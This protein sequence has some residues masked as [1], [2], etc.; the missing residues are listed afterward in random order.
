M[1]SQKANLEKEKVEFLNSMV[2]KISRKTEEKQ[3]LG[4]TPEFLEEKG[5]FKFGNY[6]V[7]QIVHDYLYLVEDFLLEIEQRARSIPNWVLVLYLKVMQ[8]N[9]DRD[10]QSQDLQRFSEFLAIKTGGDRLAEGFD[11]SLC[12]GKK[13]AKLI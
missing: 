4:I 3:I 8:W 2:Q 6:M 5:Y 11:S 9:L 1:V 12:I 7:T 10:L 13:L